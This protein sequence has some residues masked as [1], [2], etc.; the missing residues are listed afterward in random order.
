M[1]NHKIMLTVIRIFIAVVVMSLFADSRPLQNLICNL[2]L[3]WFSL[4]CVNNQLIETISSGI[5]KS[6]NHVDAVEGRE[7]D[8]I[9]NK[10]HKWTNATIPYEF[11]NNL[12]K[13]FL[14]IPLKFH[15]V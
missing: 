2:F 10:V 1:L 4:L 7:E 11:D 15:R 12:C 3:H 13:Y 6:K 9:P 14:F 5:A 8:F